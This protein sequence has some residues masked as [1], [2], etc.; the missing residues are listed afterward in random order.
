MRKIKCIT[1]DQEAKNDL[2]KHIKDRMKKDREEAMKGAPMIN[3]K[4]EDVHFVRWAFKRT[5]KE[6]L[7]YV[8]KNEKI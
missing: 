4:E 2:P 5:L 1:F 7:D 6:L 3:E 8:N